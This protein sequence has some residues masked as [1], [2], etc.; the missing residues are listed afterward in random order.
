MKE[1]IENNKLIAEFM[2]GLWNEPSQMYGI[3]NAEYIKIGKV[4]GYVKACY[5]YKL[6]DLKYHSSWD[7]LMPVVEKIERHNEFTNV[8]FFPQGCSININTENGFHFDVD[9]DAK[10]EA[11]YNACVEFIKWY[12]LNK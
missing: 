4:K 11:V 6:T 5:H 1:I 9:C 7:W 12:N 10:I 3:G 2:G 8:L